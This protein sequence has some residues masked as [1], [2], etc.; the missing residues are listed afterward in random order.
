MT[1][2]RIAFI[3]YEYAGVGG[4]GGIGTYVRNA[5]TM[6]AEHGHFVEVFC[7]PDAGVSP[8]EVAGVRINPVA[9]PR[10]D[11][12]N[13]VRAAF[14]ER[15]KLVKFNL[16][17]GPEFGADAAGIHDDFPNVALAVRL[18]TPSSVIEEINYSYVPLRAK[19]R[20]VLGALR[21]GR[22][23]K[24]WWRSKQ[25][26]EAQEER[27]HTLSANRISAPS[28]AIADLLVEKWNLP[29]EII[30]VFPNVFVPSKELLEIPI[31]S[32]GQTILFLGKLEV[33]KG[34]LELAKAIPNVINA[35]PDAKFLFVGRDL[36]MPGTSLSVGQV[37]R[38]FHRKASASVTYLEAI[39]NKD[40]PELFRRSTIA[41]FPSVWENLPYV[42]LEAM[43]AGRAVVG[44]SA[45][46]MAEIIRH[47]VTGLL[48]PPR[49]S[50]AIAGAI[51]ELLQDPRLRTSLAEEGRASVISAYAP[52]AIY[53]LQQLNYC[54][55]LQ[56]QNGDKG[57]SSLSARVKDGI[58]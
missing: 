9:G 1:E 51:V 44:S 38:R 12:S 45:G 33:R 3:S 11:F 28:K 19:A 46:G 22:V 55:A 7:G 24:L 10:A 57:L 43:A 26:S 25:A 16:I 14:T 31:Q 13:S 42:C 15:H 40:V 20:F 35:M 49:D 36:P 2:I 18:H 32:D 54:R 5:A 29:Q 50:S 23:P 41:V 58:H 37:M 6:M 34:V 56:S 21:R 27:N 48:V 52:S 4:G 8:F 30:D 17:E 39:P 53:E 47:G